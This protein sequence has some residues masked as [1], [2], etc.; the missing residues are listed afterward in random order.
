MSDNKIVN[1]FKQLNTIFLIQKNLQEDL[2]SLQRNIRKFFY[3][4]NSFDS[5]DEDTDKDKK[6]HHS[7][8]YID[9][10]IKKQKQLVVEYLPSDNEFD[11]SSSS[12]LSNYAL[13]SN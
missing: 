7:I 8:N 13:N 4:K 11:S 3:L 2:R 1:L 6:Y 12:S 5:M 9:N 10:V